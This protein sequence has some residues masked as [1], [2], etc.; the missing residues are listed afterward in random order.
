MGAQNNNATTSIAT[1]NPVPS[2]LSTVNNVIISTEY[3]TGFS[4]QV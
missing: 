3:I 2:M 4:F 1:I